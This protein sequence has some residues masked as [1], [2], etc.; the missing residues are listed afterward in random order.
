[1]QRF[2]TFLRYC[3]A[4]VLALGMTSAL[5]LANGRIVGKATDDDG[6]APLGGVSIK[7]KVAGKVLG[8][9]TGKDGSYEIRNVPA[10]TY[11][12]TASYIGFKTRNAKVTVTDDTDTKVDFKMQLDLLLLEE[13]VVIGYGTKQKKDVTSS[14]SRV[15]AKDISNLPV[16][17]VDQALQGKATG[18][19]IITASGMPGAP[20]TVRVRGAGSIASATEPL[21]VIDGIPISAGDFSSQ[22]GIRGEAGRG[23]GSNSL[24]DLNP[25]DIESIDVLKDAA[26][27]AIYGARGANGVVLITTKRGQAGIT[28]FNVNVTTGFSNPANIVKVLNRDEFVQLYTEAWNN[29]IRRGLIAQGRPV[30]WPVP[31]N[32]N[33]NVN[34]PRNNTDWMNLILR[35][36][37]LNEA[38]VSASGGSDKTKFYTGIAY[39][40]ETGYSIGN[41]FERINGRLNLDHQATEALT[42][43]ANVSVTRSVQRQFPEAWGGGLGWA[44]TGALPIFPV[45]NADGSY[46][47]PLDFWV[48]PVARAEN[49]DLSQ[50]SLR[51]LAGL[52]GELKILPEL[53]FKT[54]AS[55]DLYNMQEDLYINSAIRG[56]RLP[57]AEQRRVQVTN[58]NTNNY[59]SFNTK[60]DVHDIQATVG[61]QAQRSDQ[62]DNGVR[63]TQGS[64][65][66]YLRF[67]G[68]FVLPLGYT[69]YNNYSFLSYFARVGYKLQDKYLLNAS[70]NYNGSSRF[71]PNRQFGVFPGVSVGWIVSQ[72]DFLKGN[73]VLSYLKLRGS[74]GL[75]G[76][77]EIGNYAWRALFAPRDNYD[78]RASIVPSQ[79]PNNDLTWER[80]AQLD[81]GLEYALLDGRIQGGV[82]YYNRNSYD[83]LLPLSVATSTGFGTVLQNIGSITNSGVE[84]NI[85]SYNLTGEFQWQTD[86]NASFNRNLINDLGGLQDGVV[87]GQGETRAIVG[88]SVGTFFMNS[89]ARI[90]EKDQMLPVTR[91]RIGNSVTW[92][93]LRRDPND[94]RRNQFVDT[95]IFVRGGEPL[96]Y[97]LNG[98]LTDR[99]TVADRQPQGQPY[100]VVFGGLTNTF[101]YKGFELSLVL[102]YSIGNYVYDDAAKWAAGGTF[103]A[104]GG[105]NQRR[106]VTLRRWQKDGD[107]TDVPALTTQSIYNDLNTTRHLYR[108]DYLRLRTASIAYNIPSDI[109]SSIGLNSIRVAITGFNLLT[110]TPFP[111]WDP[112]VVR[113]TPDGAQDRNFSQGVTFLAPPQARS[114][115]F[116]LN[117]GF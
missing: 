101:R 115:N 12:V 27:T 108:A 86:L 21:Y 79:V 19:Q 15:E 11:E 68:N 92:S 107:I 57:Y 26:A 2:T 97:D 88:Y 76:N 70:V 75:T 73:E 38:S 114:V 17:S 100:P 65:N 106:D 47:R 113:D 109:C 111:Y 25:Q 105:W 8:A 28:K 81:V 117:V 42:L 63:G 64:A 45:T 55:I 18:V 104:L 50:T 62:S 37:R 72:E 82:G 40:N 66:P 83:M 93:D 32:L 58:W 84:F 59:F 96:F 69:V 3:V 24:I 71:G 53:S 16:A 91:R 13:A 30:Q 49:I 36:G 85:T 5:A 54:E 23:Y 35:T 34:D 6:N 99:Y 110:V 95:T 4:L 60:I 43:G 20:V 90:N 74:Y 48:N 103:G 1:M 94:A 22:G 9:F 89:F 87:G 80:S 56:D 39:R 33:F 112:E 14:Q 29:D 7:I 31:T 67:P 98:K 46:F 52:S 77:A 10:G 44:Q 41:S 61:F 51:T 116:S 102:N 78:G